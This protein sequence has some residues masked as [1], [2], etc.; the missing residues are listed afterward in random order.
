MTIHITSCT[1]PRWAT[2]RIIYFFGFHGWKN[3]DKVN[4]NILITKSKD[5][6]YYEIVCLTKFSQGAVSRWR[7]QKRFYF[8]NL[9]R[10]IFKI[11]PKLLSRNKMYIELPEKNASRV[12]ANR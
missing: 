6:I 8:D 12:T 9:S 3:N 4:I 7:I 1:S 10:E 2:N 5:I 11:I